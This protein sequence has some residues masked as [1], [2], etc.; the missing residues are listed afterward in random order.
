[1]ILRVGIVLLAGGE[2]V[3]RD[4]VPLVFG[5][6]G[7][8][9][10]ALVVEHE[11]CAFVIGREHAQRLLQFQRQ[12]AGLAITLRRLRAKLDEAQ[13]FAWQDIADAVMAP[14]APQFTKPWNTC[15]STPTMRVR[16]GSWP[17]ICSAA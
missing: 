1:M 6:T 7:Q 5:E 15:V 17:V 9:H 4:E 16:P 14:V 2:L 10:Q 3:R 13:H 11:V 12:G 8:H